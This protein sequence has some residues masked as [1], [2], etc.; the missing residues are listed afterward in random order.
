MGFP[1]VVNIPLG[2]SDFRRALS[3][4]PFIRV[5]NRFFEQ[6]PT[7]L[8]E[9]SALLARP[10]LQRWLTVGDGPNRGGPYSQPGSFNDAL[11]VMSGRVLYKVGT[12][13][14]ITLIGNSFFEADDETTRVSMAATA[15][16][17]LT[18]E[19]LFIADGKQ[20]KVYQP[21]TYATGELNAPSGI[22]NN[23]VV[24][25]GSVYYRFTN[26]SV[27]A[28]TPAGTVANPWLVA[29]VADDRVCLE[30]LLNAVN[31]SGVAG[32]TYSTALTANAS[33]VAI[34]TTA[35]SLFVRASAI[36]TAGNSVVTTTTIAGATW[37][38]GTLTNGADDGL[39]IVD[40]PEGLAA[41]SVAFI[42]GYIIVV[43]APREGFKGRFYWIE[44]GEITILPTNFATAER[45][46]DPLV[47]VRTV[48]D[49]FALF[50]TNSTEM[51]YPTGDVLAPFARSQSRVFER[52]LWEG[53][54]VQIK[55][56]IVMMDT[57]GT[58]YRID[59]NG[60]Q[61]ISDN[62]IEERTR[63][64]IKEAV[65]Q[66]GPPP[67]V[68]SAL[69]ATLAIAAEST[70]GAI[71]SQ[72]FQTNLVSVTG[73]VA[74][75]TYRWFWSSP[76]GGFF[77]FVGG[78]NTQLVVP[79][80]INVPNVTTVTATLN[81]EVTDAVGTRTLATPAAAYSHQNTLP[82]DAPPPTPPV[83]TFT[84]NVAYTNQATSGVN[85]QSSTFANNTATP[86]G[87]TGPYTYSWYYE[88]TS[89]G[90][91]DLSGP[92]TT[93]VVPSVTFVFDGESAVATLRCRVTDS[94]GAFGVSPQ[95]YLS[96]SNQFRDFEGFIP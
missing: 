78:A 50:G 3:K 90:N 82:V 65:T 60:P 72:T 70:S 5:R 95:I 62:S 19:R 25:I 73:G 13:F 61:R 64:A 37:T 63:A 87:G 67:P 94:L 80:V 2:T 9:G 57:D 56:T 66:V 75:Y 18:P 36:G 45:S 41:I 28:G 51:W 91:W 52:G 89:T 77:G 7:N 81:C 43:P 20:L 16:I 53:S 54:D 14:S 92:T 76:S 96:H 11:F 93:T 15:A 49:Q 8:V 29:H 10:A 68:D 4:S 83:A 12:D 47:A 17:G 33:A 55:D 21:D 85:K 1:P 39:S 84:V 42:A 38:A 32:T 46:P 26:G 74:P 88:N 22:A 58:I 27:N 79:Q 35:E 69:A 30:N 31:A 40:V 23:D 48:G 6:N 59:G 71:S 44:P 86:T 34:S 24:R